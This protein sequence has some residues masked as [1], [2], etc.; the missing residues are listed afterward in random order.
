MFQFIKNLI[1]KKKA[2]KVIAYVQSLEKKTAVFK[3][4]NIGE[5]QHFALVHD[6]SKENLFAEVVARYEVCLKEVESHNKEIRLLSDEFNLLL[7]NYPIA[8]IIDN[9]LK[10]SLRKIEEIYAIIRRVYSYIIPDSFERKA[11]YDSYKRDIERILRDY[12]MIREQKNL[13]AE[14]ENLPDIYIDAEESALVLGDKL[15]LIEKYNHYE[16]KYYKTPIID[17]HIIERHNVAFIE[18]HLRDS[19]FDSVN[20]ISLDDEQRRAVLCD[21]KSNLTI[22]GAGSGKTLTICGKV[23]YLLETG[24]A[25]NNE[26]LLLSYSRASADDLEEKVSKIADGLTVETFHSLGLRI[27]SENSGKKRT[28]EEQLKS[29]L[30]R[31]FEDELVNNPQRANE[32]FQYIALYFYSAPVYK[33]QYKDDGEIYKELK[34]LDYRTLRDRLSKLTEN[35]GKRETLKHEFVKSNEELIIA[36]YLFTNGINYEYERPYEIETGTIDKRQYTPDFYLPE[37][38]VYLEHFGI[39]KSGKTPQYD[40]ETEAKYLRSIEWKRQIHR[41]YGTKCIETYSYEFD[42]GTIFEH[43]KSRLEKSG[44]VFHPLTQSEIYNVLHYIY[45]GRDFSS[46]FNLIMTFV[47]LY[48]AQIKDDTGFDYLKVQLNESQYDTDRIRLFLNI[49]KNISLLYAKSE[50]RK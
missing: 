4:V 48:K 47:S 12:G 39:D 13:I 21:S 44:V 41:H 16:Q 46:F 22:A 6:L 33:K 18:N 43:L 7:S 36:N 40:K 9:I 5:D 35:R 27:L 11:E 45:A 23:K 17:K 37:Y 32:L 19:V 24:A 50:S 3:E 14:I 26:I 8:D 1:Y 25:K 10:C 2:K 34:S 42:E 30:T 29:Y 31:Y 38:N 28:V 20:G 49:C 15:K